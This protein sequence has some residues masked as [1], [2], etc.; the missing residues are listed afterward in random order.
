[1]DSGLAGLEHARRASDLNPLW[2]L[3]PEQRWVILGE[4]SRFVAPC[5]EWS[6]L[7][8]AR[9]RCHFQSPL[10]H[11]D[12]PEPGV[13][14]RIVLWARFDDDEVSASPRSQVHET[15]GLAKARGY[16][17]GVLLLCTVLGHAQARPSV[18]PPVLDDAR[19][20]RGT[21]S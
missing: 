7:P 16:R 8:A 4:R 2:L 17:F 9:V 1:M 20:C 11:A 14:V 5:L 13:R 3:S 6:D 10:V 19:T 12:A 21:S 15:S 18:R